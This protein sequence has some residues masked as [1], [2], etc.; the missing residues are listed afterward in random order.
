MKIFKQTECSFR[1]SKL[2][3]AACRQPVKKIIYGKI[4]SRFLAQ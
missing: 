2:K 3:K 1:I 4:I